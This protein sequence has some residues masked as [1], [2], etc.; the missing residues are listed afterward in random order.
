MW[1]QRGYDSAMDS[2]PHTAH[3]WT[4]PET[5]VASS[6]RSDY[7]SDPFRPPSS[8]ASNIEEQWAH[9]PHAPGRMDAHCDTPTEHDFLRP[10]PV[11]RLTE[12]A[13]YMPTTPLNFGSA[14]PHG[15][16]RYPYTPDSSRMLRRSAELP[17]S[18]TP[19][20]DY[21]E[22]SASPVQSAL[23]SCLAHFENLIHSQHPDE[24]QMEY[25]VGQFEAM[26]SYLSAPDA[27]SRST[28]D[29]LF[30][31]PESGFDMTDAQDA[32]LAERDHVTIEAHEAYVANVGNYIEGVKRYTED[33]KMRLDEVKTLNSIQLDVINGLRRQMLTVRR[34][35]SQSD[36]SDSFR[37]VEQEL[38]KIGDFMG[39]GADS[40]KDYGLDSLATLVDHDTSSSQLT[41]KY[42][43]KE[44]ET[45]LIARALKSPGRRTVS[46]VRK[47]QT[48]SFWT[49]I[50]EALDSFGSQLLDS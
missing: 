8:Y 15:A 18:P 7:F 35:M 14:N 10:K 42:S 31:E 17:S 29:H 5:E 4:P 26:T 32:R 50:A 9:H 46:I 21:S 20:D 3:P 11:G 41:Q 30:N 45:R 23:S 37:L 27:Q 16:L 1:Q 44:M 2:P 12:P 13:L 28:D 22:H 19:W 36:M 38:E 25:I 39:D 40:Q 34:G 33:L 24:D 47:P 6:P 43:D 48:R 49:S